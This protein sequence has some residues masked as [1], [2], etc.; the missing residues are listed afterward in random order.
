MTK[1]MLELIDAMV[2]R[3]AEQVLAP[4]LEGAEF[5]ALEAMAAEMRH[6]RKEHEAS[7]QALRAQAARDAADMRVARRQLVAAEAAGLSVEAALQ[8]ER[9]ARQS[10]AHA[11]ELDQSIQRVRAAYARYSR[12]AVEEFEASIDAFE[13][14]TTASLDRVARGTSVGVSLD[15]ATLAEVRMAA[16]NV[17][18][19]R[20]ED[21]LAELRL[22][23]A[24]DVAGDMAERAAPEILGLHPIVRQARAEDEDAV[25]MRA[26]GGEPQQ[27]RP[28]KEGPM[29]KPE[30][31]QRAKAQTMA[32]EAKADSEAEA[33][34]VAAEAAA[35][36]AAEAA[37]EAAA[38]VGAEM[39][40][41]TGAR[42][43]DLVG[44]ADALTAAAASDMA[45]A[46]A[47][48][49]N[50]PEKLRQ[51]ATALQS[52][53]IAHRASMAPRKAVNTTSPE[54]AAA[55][56]VQASLL[57]DASVVGA[58]S[59]SLPPLLMLLMEAL[60]LCG[61]ELQVGVT[62]PRELVRPLLA[63]SAVDESDAARANALRCVLS[64]SPGPPLRDAA[65]STA[66]LILHIVPPETDQ[67][68]ALP[69]KRSTTACRGVLQGARLGFVRL[70]KDGSMTFGEWSAIVGSE[71]FDTSEIF[72]IPRVGDDASRG[73]AL[74]PSPIGVKVGVPSL[75]FGMSL[76]SDA[77]LYL[78][79]SPLS[80]V[81][82]VRPS[83]RWSVTV[84]QPRL[85]WWTRI[86][87]GRMWSVSL[88][89]WDWDEQ[90]GMGWEAASERA[91]R[92]H[93]HPKAQ[94]GEEKEEER[95]SLSLSALHGRCQRWCATPLVFDR[96]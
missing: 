89:A 63:K 33:E 17:G 9:Q 80:N 30:H 36:E 41:L 38:A 66:D 95:P 51:A 56:A 69:L 23:Q 82:L 18:V 4:A 48:A 61:F 8:L 10:D 50:L 31:Q 12:R 87:S 1:A 19:E 55:C 96:T 37:A 35:Q 92:G 70:A 68:V 91:K 27:A 86:P 20:L 54:G 94:G 65:L 43:T 73:A 26:G 84:P 7:V 83:V 49:S 57:I 78:C 5:C 53:L 39:N 52:D 25:E 34:A 62:G 77:F 60:R 13:T 79:S 11:G 88:S 81:T 47:Y 2:A 45:D 42:E 58:E 93:G 15:L 59:G 44:G 90:K 40:E 16:V 6:R 3:L 22:K 85:S 67:G 74:D 75:D 64:A 46:G 32:A 29:P 72:E 14:A 71:N 21:V 28:V 24:D 76:C